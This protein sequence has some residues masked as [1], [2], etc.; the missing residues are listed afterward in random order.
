MAVYQVKS[1][2]RAG[3]LDGFEVASVKLAELFRLAGRTGVCEG[4]GL[5]GLCGVRGRGPR[6]G[7]RAGSATPPGPPHRLLRHKRAA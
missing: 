5:A 6:Y 4:R 2:K 3:F 1:K 7:L